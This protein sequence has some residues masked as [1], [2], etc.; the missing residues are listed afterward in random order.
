ML[1]LTIILATVLL[2]ISPSSSQTYTAEDEMQVPVELQLNIFVKVLK[3]DRALEEKKK[4]EIV[5][6]ILYHARV[7]ESYLAKDQLIEAIRATQPSVQG[8][9][10][11]AVPLTVTTPEELE[12]A[13]VEHGLDLLYVGPVR[14][15]NVRRFTPVTRARSVLTLTGVPQFV[16]DGVAI[17]IGLAG[18]KPEIIVNMESARS[19]GANLQAR[20]LNLARII[21]K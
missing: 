11:R 3:F 15:M 17:G 6:G 5:L 13:I 21:E 19:E 2:G 4:D 14:A 10:I 12:A 16:Q 9:P 7:R 20:L 8:R 18:D 1:R